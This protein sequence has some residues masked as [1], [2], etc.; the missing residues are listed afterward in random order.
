LEY[1]I[2]DARN[3]PKYTQ[4]RNKNKITDVMIYEGDVLL[5]NGGGTY[6]HK[7]ERKRRRW[8]V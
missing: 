2:K 4:R 3:S 7:R 6:K 8:N 1:E 5:S